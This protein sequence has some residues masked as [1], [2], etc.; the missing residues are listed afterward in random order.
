MNSFLATRHAFCI[1][2]SAVVPHRKAVLTEKRQILRLPPRHF[3]VTL[4]TVRTLVVL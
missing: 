4:C 2:K 3:E 1:P